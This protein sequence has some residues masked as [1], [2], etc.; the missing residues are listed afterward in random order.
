[1]LPPS[2]GL[3]P[4]GAKHNLTGCR[5]LKRSCETLT[6]KRLLQHAPTQHSPRSCCRIWSGHWGRSSHR[7]IH[8]WCS[9]SLDCTACHTCHNAHGWSSGPGGSTEQ[10]RGRQAATCSSDA[11]PLKFRLVI[12]AAATHA[13]CDTL[14]VKYGRH[15]GTIGCLDCSLTCQH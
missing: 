14:P 9:Q 1:M 8:R 10:E 13:M 4:A 11:V 7:R 2:L 6:V 15:N 12:V 3:L 5:N